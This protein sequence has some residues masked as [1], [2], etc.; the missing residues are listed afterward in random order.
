MA[1]RRQRKKKP[2]PYMAGGVLMHSH[3]VYATKLSEI[4]D[5]RQRK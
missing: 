1:K 3:L 4:Q 5:Q 2:Q